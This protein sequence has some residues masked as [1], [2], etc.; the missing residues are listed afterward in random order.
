M[1]EQMVWQSDSSVDS[2]GEYV[3][4]HWTIFSVSRYV[5]SFYI[6]YWEKCIRGNLNESHIYNDKWK[7]IKRKST[8]FITP[9]A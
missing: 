4:A 3:Y 7:V 2:D 8:Y 5:W 1:D 6:K 9:I